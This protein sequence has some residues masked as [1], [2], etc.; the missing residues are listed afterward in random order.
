MTLSPAPPCSGSRCSPTLNRDTAAQWGAL[1][2]LSLS[3]VLGVGRSADARAQSR[4][5][6][7]NDCSFKKPN[8]LLVLDY[9]SSMSGARDAPAYFPLGQSVTTRWDAELTAASWILRYDQGF[10]ANNTRIGLT[11]GFVIKRR[12]AGFKGR[13]EKLQRLTQRGGDLIHAELRQ[14]YELIEQDLVAGIQPLLRQAVWQ[15]GQTEPEA[16]AHFGT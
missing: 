9:S 11:R 5:E 10:F 6:D 12:P 3:L 13:E 2:W 4:C 8:V 7:E 14:R 1:G 16:R 15:P